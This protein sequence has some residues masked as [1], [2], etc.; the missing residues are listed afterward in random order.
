MYMGEQP[1][2]KENK[3]K[4]LQGGN[5]GSWITYKLKLDAFVL[6]VDETIFPKFEKLSKFCTFVPKKDFFNWILHKT[7][8]WGA[9]GRERMW[10][11]VGWKV[12]GDKQN[13]VVAVCGQLLL[14]YKKIFIGQLRTQKASTRDKRWRTWRGKSLHRKGFFSGG[15]RRNGCD[16]PE[17]EKPKNSR[18]FIVTKIH[19]TQAGVHFLPCFLL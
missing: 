5:R 6:G 2:R 9:N 11:N 1:V 10:V 19:K 18:P 7:R 17:K 4:R 8:E 13:F 16:V 3:T 15:A 14:T 12:W